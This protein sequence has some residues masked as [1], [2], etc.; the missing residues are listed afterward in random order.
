[1]V[2][3]SK[4]IIS[5]KNKSKIFIALLTSLSFALTACNFK[6]VIP[7]HGGNGNSGD[8]EEDIQD[9]FVDTEGI[10]QYVT[11]DK[12]TLNLLPGQKESVIF[13]IYAEGEEPSFKFNWNN[14][15]KWSSQNE[16]VATVDKGE[17]TAVNPGSTKI[18]ARI[19]SHAGS[20][21]TVNVVERIAKSL[22]IVNQRKTFLLNSTFKASYTC[23]AV[24][25]HDLKEDITSST[26]YDAS[27]VNM[28][29]E[30]TYPVYV[31]YSSGDVNLETSYNVTVL[32]NVNYTPKYLDYTYNDL[33][34]NNYYEL[35][36]GNYCPS[37]G[38]AKTLVI[39]IW[40]TDSNTFISDKNKL[41]NQIKEAFFGEARA[42]GWNSVKS[43]YEEESK[44]QLTYSGT[45][46]DWYEPGYSYATLGADPGTY[47]TQL[48][49]NAVDNYFS[50]HP[51]E[52]PSDYDKDNNGVMDGLY[53]LY[54]CDDKSGDYETYWGKILFSVIRERSSTV[55]GISFYMWA[56]ALDANRDVSEGRNDADSHVFIHEVGHTFGLADYYNYGENDNYRP[57][58]GFITMEHNTGSQDPFSC[59][60][61][62]WGKV[63]VPETSTI[64]ELE[65]YER[66]RQ[67]ILLSAHPNTVNSPFDEYILV[68][69]YTPN[70]LNKFDNTYQ[71]R[72]YY[73]N[74]PTN[75]GVRIW[76]VDGRLTKKIDDE[77]TTELFT[78]PTVTNSMCAFTNSWGD[79]HGDLL[80]PDYY[81][82]NLL[83][84]VRNDVEETK[85]GN[86]T[87]VVNDS[88][89]F[90]AGDIFTIDKFKSQFVKENKLN[91]GETFPWKITVEN[92]STDSEGSTSTISIEYLD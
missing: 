33:D 21:V 51:L 82:Y 77:Y 3:L 20:Y 65:D 62:H 90:H 23:N 1:M 63:F 37:R 67:A 54:G 34:N 91:S 30:G 6:I 22:E 76:H 38:Q 41:R 13:T 70:K 85:Y 74:G 16:N 14:N 4:G 45:V 86:K 27:A 72:G 56:S 7:G 43:F 28:A 84:S 46:A 5:M 60:S 9:Y 49:L 29:A 59:T 15:A 42:N 31:R 55:T 44:G 52:K 68:E 83:Y 19:F 61:L 71:W 75:P 57:A 78:D 73:S 24:Y 35:T 89:L 47:Q 81:D 11:T 12:K 17:I 87:L 79:N 36:R 48:V 92:I 8:K 25:E 66:S 69:L 53:I 39:P 80:G 50:N 40:F 10:K 88:V 32:E 64:I 26:T 58:G 2:D 18:L